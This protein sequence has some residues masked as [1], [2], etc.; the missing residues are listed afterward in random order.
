MTIG[1][2]KLKIINK[3]IKCVIFNYKVKYYEDQVCYCNFKNFL[4]IS[5]LQKS[6]PFKCLKMY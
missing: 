6:N 3:M 1:I 5:Y 2:S 4:V